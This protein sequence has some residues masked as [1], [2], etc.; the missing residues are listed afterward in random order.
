MGSLFLPDRCA[1]IDTVGSNVL[2]RGNM[3]LLVSWRGGLQERP[4]YALEEIRDA[5]GVSDLLSRRFIEIPIIDNLGE[6][7]QLEPLL[8]SFG[9]DP[10][11]YPD[12]LWPWW[13]H[14]DYDA[15]ALRGTTLTTEGHSIPGALCWRPFEGLPAQTDPT[16]FL[17]KDWDFSGFIDNVI[18]LTR[19]LENSA[20]Y[21]HCQLGADRTGAFHTGY[22]MRSRGLSLAD[23][24]KISNSA[25]SAGEPNADYRRLL[26]AYSAL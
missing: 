25:T 6:W 23:A 8:L 21:V 7:Q 16:S 24:G 22:L 5:S 3:P 4:H 18:H 15:N 12:T 19:T 10:N 17:T 13:Q 14:A 20:I 2:I 26:E 9:L 11:D 1:H